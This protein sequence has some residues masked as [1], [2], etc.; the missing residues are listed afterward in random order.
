M[1]L[2]RGGQDQSVLLA[3]GDELARGALRLA[4]LSLLDGD[5]PA[6]GAG[7]LNAAFELLPVFGPSMQGVDEGEGDENADEVEGD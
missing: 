5:G 1:K 3:A 4:V 6:G 7:A 2:W